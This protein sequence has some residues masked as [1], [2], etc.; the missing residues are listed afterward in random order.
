MTDPS[1]L[2][3][4]STS[5]TL[6]Q[7]AHDEAASPPKRDE[8]RHELL[9]RYLE[10]VRRYLAGAL[11]LERGR[12]EV[13]DEL[14]QEFSLRVMRGSLQGAHPDR[15]R[16]RNFL[17]VMLSNLVCDHHRRRRRQPGPLGDSE[18]GSEDPPLPGEEEF[19]RMWR[20]QL[21]TRALR[22]LAAFERTSGQVLYT[23]L[24][25][26]LDEPALSSE[27]LAGR[28]AGQLGREVTAAW[29][30]KRLFLARQKLRELIRAE[31]RQSLSDPTD[32]TVDAELAEVGLLAYLG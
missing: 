30:R 18:K 25:R 15:G 23:V 32:E 19:T 12:D 22:A 2:D 20:E 16:F 31:V 27:E 21:V 4:L 28:L 3:E 13:V 11:R 5:W 26:A 1:R 10:L 9:E 7:A 29:V 8:A 6:L 17:K 24:K 14:V